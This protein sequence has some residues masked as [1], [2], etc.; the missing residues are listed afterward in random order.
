M[1][2]QTDTNSSLDSL[3]EEIFSL[4]NSIIRGSTEIEA[5]LDGVVTAVGSAM[6]DGKDNTRSVAFAAAL[7]KLAELE[8]TGQELI[9]TETPKVDSLFET[10]VAK[11]PF[12]C[13]VVYVLHDSFEFAIEEL[14]ELL[15]ISE[16]E[17]KAYLHRARLEMV[18]SMRAAH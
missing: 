10:S 13:R 5:I 12:E 17:V 14:S 2:L 1:L 8:E 18:R 11:L 7:S 6:K 15:K 16:L 9:P 4:C 3:P